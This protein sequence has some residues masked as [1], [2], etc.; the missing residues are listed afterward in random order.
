MKKYFPAILSFVL[1]L[2]MF[3]AIP[4]SSRAAQDVASTN[5]AIVQ[6]ELALDELSIVAD[7]P[8]QTSS[9]IDENGNV[10]TQL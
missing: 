1:I 4:M 8:I 2:G 6:A 3:L 7:E 5:Q 10:N 9:T